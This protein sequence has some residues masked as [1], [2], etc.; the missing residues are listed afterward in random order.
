MTVTPALH[1]LEIAH[2]A[3]VARNHQPVR[4]GDGFLCRCGARLPCSASTA[5]L[6]DIAADWIRIRTGTTGTEPESTSPRRE[7]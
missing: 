6:A 4:R 2:R 3:F 5:L 1:P 7:P